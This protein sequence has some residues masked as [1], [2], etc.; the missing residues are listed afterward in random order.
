MR[1][2]GW[3][4]S[5]ALSRGPGYEPLPPGRSFSTDSVQGYFLDFS[6][7]T[8]TPSAKT[9]GL[10]VPAGLVQLA[11]GWWER[12]LD[13]GGARRDEF[14]RVCDVLVGRGERRG[15][16]LL[17]PYDVAVAKFGL[18]PPWHSA[19]AQGQAASALVRAYALTGDDGYADAARAAVHPLLEP[20]GELVTATA[21]GP[22]LEEAPSNPPSHILN[23]W[24][25]ALWGVWDIAV[26]LDDARAENVFAASLAALRHQ[27]PAYDV[28]W[29][30]RYSL[31][32]HAIDD[33]AKPI[34]HRLH[35]D[36]LD[37]LHRLTGDAE[38]GETSE[39]WRAYDTAL[40]RMGAVAQKSVFVV[41]DAP[42]RRRRSR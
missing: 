24:V 13:E 17:W 11:L 32:P 31:Y 42:R 9:P 21:A 8:R 18:R 5:S 7:K 39:R 25:S 1:T 10:L 22:I 37:V 20:D 19:L 16:A 23:G 3:A 2:A 36:Q 27:L 4:W 14:L 35:V 40:S 38:F 30:T 6:E 41:L 15:E 33:L 29:W 34:Y 28:G 26:G 12:S